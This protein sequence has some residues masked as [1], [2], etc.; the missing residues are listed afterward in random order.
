MEARRDPLR[1]L[2]EVGPQHHVAQLGL[3]D[4]DQLQQLVLAG[5]DVGEHP[6]LFQRLAVEVLRLVEDQHHPPPVGVFLDQIG[7]QPREEVDVVLARA[8]GLVQ[9]HQ[10]PAQQLAA[11]ALGVGDQRHAD[12]VLDLAQQMLQQRRLAG[13][14]LARYERDRRAG[15]DAVFEDRVRAQMDRP[16][17]HE[18]RIG[19]RARTAARADRNA[20]CR[21]RSCCSWG[22]FP[23]SPG[24]SA[25]GRLMIT[26]RGYAPGPRS[27][28]RAESRGA[29]IALIQPLAVHACACYYIYLS[30]RCLN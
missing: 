25:I 30:L 16:P 22:P 11:A 27:T 1:E 19:Q 8:G 5:I 4:Q 17:V 14:H 20:R 6:Q 21:C 29:A 26:A 23:A 18:V 12:V 28:S 24:P 10:H 3:A 13:P 15:Q 7:L 9:R 2:R